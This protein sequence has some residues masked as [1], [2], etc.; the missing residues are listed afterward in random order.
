MAQTLFASTA[1]TALF[2][3]NVPGEIAD[4]VEV[5]KR[6]GYDTI[7]VEDLKALRREL[8]LLSVGSRVYLDQHNPSVTNLAE[9]ELP[10][11]E[12]DNGSN[13]GLALARG[14]LP[15]LLP[16]G[17]DVEVHL[18]SLVDFEP[19]TNDDI[20]TA[21]RRRYVRSYLSKRELD[22]FA[23]TLPPYVADADAH[24]LFPAEIEV[25]IDEQEHEKYVREVR[26]AV[27]ILSEWMG[28]DRSKMMAC[29][30]W[31]DRDAADWDH[32]HAD[33]LENV[34]Y[35]MLRRARAIRTIK[36]ALLTIYKGRVS[37]ENDVSWLKAP[38][39]HLRNRSPWNMILS[40]DLGQLSDVAA[41]AA[42]AL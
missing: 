7:V 28:E 35:D 37:I 14:A 27:L 40:S 39:E 5:A 25:V 26:S 16:K 1:P 20:E 38:E 8:T 2:Y 31:P 11:V 32:V 41:I 30:G 13:V 22:D 19:G 10:E 15:D 29:L 3:D 42:K 24:G 6:R 34:N 33:L 23:Q 9:I 17:V 36:R 12:T 18:L 21:L 4:H